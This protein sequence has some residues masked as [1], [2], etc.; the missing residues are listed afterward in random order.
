MQKYRAYGKHVAEVIRLAMSAQFKNSGDLASVLQV[1]RSSASRRVRGE[2]PFKISEVY[3]VA[4]WLGTTVGAL[5]SQADRLAESRA[6]Q[7]KRPTSE[8]SYED[9]AVIAGQQQVHVHQPKQLE[10]K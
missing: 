3:K 1:S 10:N 4:G 6:K 2:V 7:L 5:I 8:P 9:S